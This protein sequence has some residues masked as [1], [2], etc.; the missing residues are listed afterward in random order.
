MSQRMRIPLRERK[1]KVASVQI[2]RDIS[3]VLEKLHMFVILCIGV[4][5][6]LSGVCV[7]A[8]AWCHSVCLGLSLVSV[9][10]YLFLSFFPTDQEVN[11]FLLY[12]PHDVLLQMKSLE[13]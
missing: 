13:P 1:K 12:M 9:D 7:C 10:V 3:L 4:S 8:R 5:A 2:N 6:C 11:R